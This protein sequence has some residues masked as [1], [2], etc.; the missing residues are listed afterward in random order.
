MW[1]LGRRLT[2]HLGLIVPTGC[3]IYVGDDTPHTWEE[4]K[5]IVFDDSFEHYVC[6]FRVQGSHLHM[7]S[8]VAEHFHIEHSW[9]LPD[10]CCVSIAEQ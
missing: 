3:S 9:S 5:C 8:I 10:H 6:Q 4:G 7:F 2:V 1:V